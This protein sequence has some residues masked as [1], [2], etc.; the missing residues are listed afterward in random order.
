MWTFPVSADGHVF[1]A[2]LPSAVVKKEICTYEANFQLRIRE[3]LDNGVS[4][5][6]NACNWSNTD[7]K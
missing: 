6:W 5:P 1:P 3:M 4:E 2:D 7:K